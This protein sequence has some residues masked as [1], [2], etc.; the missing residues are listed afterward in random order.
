MTRGNYPTIE[1]HTHAAAETANHF[2]G[3]GFR[4]W[5]TRYHGRK[6][7]Q[8]GYSINCIGC[9]RIRRNYGKGS[10]S[11]IGN[12]FYHIDRSCGIGQRLGWIG[13]ALR[14]HGRCGW[15]RNENTES[16]TERGHALTPS[17]EILLLLE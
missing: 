9:S 10:G 1:A 8:F 7:N 11:N 14:H 15:F 2:T 3:R 13:R 6:G 12:H 4:T 5:L 16:V 17:I